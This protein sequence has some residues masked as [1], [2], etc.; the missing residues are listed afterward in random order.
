MASWAFVPFTLIRYHPTAHDVHSDFPV[1]VLNRPASQLVH[2]VCAALIAYIPLLHGVHALCVC[3]FVYLPG[4][5]ASQLTLC[6]SAENVP[7]PQSMQSDMPGFG[8]KCPALHVLH[9]ED[10]SCAVWSPYFPG[11]QPMQSASFSAPTWGK[12][13]PFEQ[14]VQSGG[15]FV[16]LSAPYLPCGHGLSQTQFVRASFEVVPIMHCEQSAFVIEPDDI[17]NHPLSH[18]MHSDFSFAAWYWPAPQGLHAVAPGLEARAYL[19]ASH[20]TQGSDL[21]GW[22]LPPGHPL[23]MQPD[24][25]AVSIETVTFPAAHVMQVT[26]A[27][28][29]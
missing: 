6:A 15:F 18:L 23:T 7:T 25:E 13:R 14:S 16:W 10:A 29:S 17:R 20:V 1:V 3:A 19:P 26:C 2:A 11:K 24:S 5:H 27:G 12:Y 21:V 8:A 28:E 9:E 22:Y 4:A